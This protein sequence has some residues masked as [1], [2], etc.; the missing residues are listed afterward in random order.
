MPHTI[1]IQSNKKMKKLF[2]AAFVALL[3]I[4]LSSCEDGTDPTSADIIGSWQL[5]HEFK[6]VK[7]NNV[8]DE[9]LTYNEPVTGGAVITFEDD[10]TGDNDGRAFTWSLS[11][12]TLTMDYGNSELAPE[13]YTVEKVTS[14]EALISTI[15]NREEE[16]NDIEEYF[17]MTYNR[18]K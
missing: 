16:G 11:G 5:T 8:V 1:T 13:E 17:R 15:Y 12:K 2:L 7:V 9:S 10:N 14:S 3:A 6:Q 4:N 18:M